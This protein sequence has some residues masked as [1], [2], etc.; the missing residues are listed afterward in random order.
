MKNHLYPQPHQP[1]NGSFDDY[2]SVIG[3]EFSVN[4][5]SAK[6]SPAGEGGDGGSNYSDDMSSLGYSQ[7]G[8]T[9]SAANSPARMNVAAAAAASTNPPTMATAT[10]PDDSNVEWKF[11]Q[12]WTSRRR[13]IDDLGRRRQNTQWWRFRICRR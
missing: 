10:H 6:G 5:T 12:R 11:R 3:N 13:R 9:N 2:D 4:S 8:P 7:V 1:S